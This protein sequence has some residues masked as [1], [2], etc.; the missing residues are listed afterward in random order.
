ME[1][2]YTGFIQQLSADSSSDK[3]SV[4]LESDP[5]GVDTDRVRIVL[6][7]LLDR[8]AAA[9][10]P[11]G[12][13]RTLIDVGRSARSSGFWRDH[14]APG[15][16]LFVSEAVHLTLDLPRAPAPY[17]GVGSAFRV[18]DVYAAAQEPAYAV[19]ALS[20]GAARFFT[21]SDGSATL[22]DIPDMP[23]NLDE[24][25]RFADFE[26]SLQRHATARGG[27]LTSHGQEG[28][29]RQLDHLRDRYL[30][31][32]DAAINGVPGLRSL[33]VVLAGVEPLTAAF[34]AI[35]ALPNLAEQT[36][37]GN[38]DRT[39]AWQLASMATA[40]ARPEHPLMSRDRTAHSDPHRRTTTDANDVFKAAQDGRVETVFLKH[41]QRRSDHL[42]DAIAIEVTRHGGRVWILDEAPDDV[43]AVLRY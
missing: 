17:A 18:L 12:V 16:A 34:Q 26:P 30:R 25:A 38:H 11:E 21:M 9:D 5:T 22:V 31:L 10:L 3:V 24:V 40:I 20:A 13:R 41:D 2:A 1:S 15:L 35:S 7:D 39:S 19:L 36:I 27:A 6:R 33:P 43:Q 28:G 14:R 29:S 42:L 32:I 4:L 23:V 8:V 37:T